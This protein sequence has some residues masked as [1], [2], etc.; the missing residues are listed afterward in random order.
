VCLIRIIQKKGFQ[1][2]IITAWKITTHLKRSNC[3]LEILAKTSKTISRTYLKSLSLLHRVPLSKMPHLQ[4]II[5]AYIHPQVNTNKK[6][7]S[8]QNKQT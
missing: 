8:N 7:T 2:N 1:V 4:S 3:L 6:S 5:R